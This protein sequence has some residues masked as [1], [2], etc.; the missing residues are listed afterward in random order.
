[1]PYSEKFAKLVERINEHPDHLVAVIVHLNDTYLLDER[2]AQG[3]PGF[4]RLIATVRE[5]RKVVAEVVKRR[6]DGLPFDDYDRVIV[7]HSGDFL[8]PSR[9]GMT[10]KGRAMVELLNRA[11][12]NF[13]VLGNHEMDF[14]K[15]ELVGRLRE[16]ES[17]VL[18][19]NIEA[20]SEIAYQQIA[21]WPSDTAPAIA[22][23]GVISEDVRQAFKG[24]KFQKP[25]VFLKHFEVVTRAVPFR[26]P[27]T[28]ALREEDR[29]LREPLFPADRC[30][31]LGG[32]DHYVDWPEAD[33][34]PVYKNRSN[35]HS[36]RVFVLKAGGHRAVNALGRS[37]GERTKSGP[38]FP[39][40]TKEEIDAVLEP[41]PVVDA[42]AFRASLKAGPSE[43]RQ[44]GLAPFADDDW[45]VPGDA[46]ARRLAGLPSVDDFV[47]HLLKI[48]DCMPAD[49][50]DEAWV[51]AHLRDVRKDDRSGV[52]CDFTA[53]TEFLDAGDIPLRSQL[54]DFGVFVAECVRRAARADVAILNSG[55]FRAD[56]KLPSVLTE[57]DLRDT[58]LFDDYDA[59]KKDKRAIVVLTLNA[60]AV[61]AL[62][63]FARD[64]AGSGA[65][66]QVSDRRDTSKKELV[67]AI[68]GY[69]MLDDESM[70]RYTKPLMEQWKKTEKEVQAEVRSR[71]SNRLT[72]VGSVMAHAAA[73]PYERPDVPP[74]A[75]ASDHFVLLAHAASASFSTGPGATL[76]WPRPWNDAFS[77]AIGSDT[78]TGDPAFDAGRDRLRVFLRAFIAQAKPAEWMALDKLHAELR[79]HPAH[80]RDDLDYHWILRYAVKDLTIWHPSD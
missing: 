60:D 2:K 8:G 1:M 24:W 41:L 26:I 32:H 53:D 63:D 40:Y 70:D 50:A 34:T 5:L 78:S 43:G 29:E 3:F 13:C 27:L 15:D 73:V 9:I 4:P 39:R 20:P 61:D 45:D 55:C 35:L 56:M 18:L 6:S 36:I 72:I 80:F 16:L 31:I 52:L 65:Y 74:P 54:T 12:L 57:S 21:L 33:R 68:N 64:K 7:V 48:D 10:D 75:K 14:G 66:P 58:F 51:E 59:T 67:V 19:G 17:K 38:V 62:I 44:V 25:D 76:E 22:F 71:L 30:F 47:P 23:T 37:Y 42:Q 28:H 79:A 69:V 46:L 11:G 77:K 49:T